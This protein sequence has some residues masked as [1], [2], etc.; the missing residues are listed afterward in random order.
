MSEIDYEG[1]APAAAGASTSLLERIIREGKMAR[2]E[3]QLAHA[4]DILGTFVDEVLDKSMAPDPDTIVMVQ[5]RIAQIDE[6]ISAQLNEILHAEPFQKLESAWRGLYYLV[7]N[8]ETSQ[9]LKIRV[10]PATKREV[11][12]DLERTIEFD[13]S[14]LFKKIYEEE[15]GTFGGEPFGVLIG[16]YHFDRSPTDMT[17]LEKMSQVAA[18][19]HAP[20]LAGASAR[21]FDL[22]DFTELTLPRD[23]A[24]IFDSSEMTKWRS[25]RDSEDSRYVALVLPS[26]LLR[27]PYGPETEPVEGFNFVEDVDGKDAK[28]YLWGNAAY[29]LGQRVTESFALY[30]WTA[31]I[32][33]VEGGGM[34]ERLPV[35]TFSTP[36]GDKAS[37]GP[38]E[39]GVTDRRER[40]LDELGFITLSP[41]KGQDYAVF[42]GAKTV[43]K[44]KLYDT[45]A[46]NANASLSTQ[47]PYILAAS[48]FAHYLKA[49]MRD[50]IGSFANEG[51]VSAYLNRWIGGYIEL[52]DDAS[53]EIKARRPLRDA[54]VDV[55]P[56]P[57]KPG[58][59]KATIFLRPH[60]QLNE[61]TAS[62]R[63]VTELP[64]AAR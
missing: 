45:A 31:A 1:G 55:T 13:Q 59:Y 38:V 54:R 34:V 44:A 39:V 53:A 42:F 46:A 17:L 47:L 11:F 12:L 3:R 20:F 32:R 51:T 57:G 40:E 29:A 22:D 25:F 30:R 62:I 10:L 4:R 36:A 43:N 61:L 16:D 63:L 60:F 8:T 49:M 19:A 56:V 50:K 15:F 33:G 7:K 48:R 58:A 27:L 41:C 2:D 9:E 23:L 5:R 35:H 26:M 37:K 28:K 52:N 18:A 14:S 64:Q 6:M 24:K 21:L